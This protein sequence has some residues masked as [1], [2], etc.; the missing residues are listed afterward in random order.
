M[1]SLGVPTAV[2]A[3]ES[4]ENTHF[5][6]AQDNGFPRVRRVVIDENFHA[7]YTSAAAGAGA[8]Y[9]NE[10][11]ARASARVTSMRAF[12]ERDPISE[13]LLSRLDATYNNAKDQM[14]FMDYDM[15]QMA[16]KPAIVQAEWALIGPMT[17]NDINP[18]PITPQELG[19][20][21][22]SSITFTA[23][24]YDEAV[25]A[26][27]KYAMDNFFGD[28]L[29]LV[30]PTRELV[31]EM[32][33]GTTRQPGDVLGKLHMRAG[34]ITIEK[35]AV[36]AVMAGA[37][38]EYFPVILAG[39]EAFANSW[40]EDF[41]WWHPQTS[42]AGGLSIMMLVSGPIAEEIGLSSDVAQLGAGNDVNNVIGRTMRLLFRTMAHNLSPDIDTS[43]YTP[44]L[45]DIMNVR[46]V[47]ENLAA[48]PPGWI[49][50]SELSGFGQGSNSIT[51]IGTQTS[52]WAAGSAFNGNWTVS[53]LVNLLPNVPPG[54]FAAA[55]DGVVAMYSPAQARL[56]WEGDPANTNAVLRDGFKTKQAMI[57]FRAPANETAEVARTFRYPV[58]VGGDPGGA[59]A[60]GAWVYVATCY[61]TQKIT[62]ATLTQAG[63]GN[64]A[65]SSPR[66][67][68]VTMNEAQDTAYLTWEAPISDGGRPIT[69]YQVYFLNGN[70]DLNFRWLDIPGGAEARSAFFTNL[71]PGVQYF[72]RVRARN[73]V[74][75]AYYYI[76]AEGDGN[77]A[78]GR[79]P[80]AFPRFTGQLRIDRM[81]GKGGWA[82]APAITPAGRLSTLNSNS[83][84]Q[85]NGEPIPLYHGNPLLGGSDVRKFGRNGQIFNADGT[86]FTNTL[87]TPQITSL[88]TN[89]GGALPYPVIT[90]NPIAGAV[91]Y[92]VYVYNEN[93]DINPN[94]QPI[95][96]R[97]ASTPV[98]PGH[99]RVNNVPA[100]GSTFEFNMDAPRFNVIANFFTGNDYLPDSYSFR[101]EPPLPQG[102]YWF[103]VQALADRSSRLDLN[104]ALSNV[105]LTYTSSFVPASVAREIMEN[106]VAGVDY[107][108]VALTMASEQAIQGVIRGSVTGSIPLTGNITPAS[109][110]GWDKDKPIFVYCLGGLRSYNAAIRLRAEGFTKVYDLGGINQW[111]YGRVFNSQPSGPVPINTF[112]AT[113]ITL[114]ESILTYG[115]LPD[116]VTYNIFV[117][118]NNTSTDP[119]DA[120][121]SV[122][123]IPGNGYWIPAGVSAQASN[124]TASYDLAQ[125][126]DL[127]PGTYYVRMQ[128]VA[129]N[130]ALFHS[131][132]LQ[133]ATRKW[134]ASV[135]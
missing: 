45:S 133:P 34:T 110:S 109:V 114:S 102:D 21:N 11:Q 135:P 54:T 76:N 26:F 36:N 80:S 97:L 82:M 95:R 19:D 116:N 61:Q 38:P 77:L 14:R 68:Q 25:W 15:W 121:R 98:A 71:Q 115:S 24:S 105:S 66:N 49:S 5:Y 10:A 104:S 27:N 57:D 113:P 103:R 50:H 90:W 117:F 70:Q 65:P 129:Q 126:D 55:G 41:S 46:V 30:P 6:G 9:P 131:K 107:M 106:G 39:A 53:A 56:L 101:N 128:V 17:A 64:T 89:I 32:L 78:G 59:Y 2:V 81:G 99:E 122:T 132:P 28:G 83:Y 123:G 92:L 22:V 67:L 33:A 37:L 58:V 87:V 7:A 108:L 16:A 75:N 112:N 42:G 130:Q 31:D 43:G 72:F 8:E 29:P 12:F 20:L 84:P 119:Q 91:D 94:A 23:P 73:D 51:L 3:P 35:L 52:P 62:G 74:D 69:Q 48:L 44:R 47:A 118:N 100:L 79:L 111:P 127:R 120:V 60:F 85:L 40:E 86:E 88:F 18:P 125:I 93:P 63:R 96:T 13:K 124:F 4:Y 134:W 1:E